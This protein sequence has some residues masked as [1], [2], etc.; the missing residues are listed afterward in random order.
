MIIIVMGVSGSG[1]S[2]I[3][4]ALAEKL[5]F[6]FFDADDF[7]PQSNKDKMASGIP[8]TDE[9][10]YPWLELIVDALSKEN[11]GVLACSALKDTYREIL[12]KAS[13][14][15]RWVYLN[16]DYETIKQRMEQ[17][18]GHFMKADMLK[19]QFDA[20]QAP[21]EAINVDITLSIGEIVATV[22]KNINKAND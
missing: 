22:I 9:D 1:K 8:L 12:N 20:L 19:S 17:R 16:G 7:H 10:R 2:T 18:S 11:N 21:S 5:K 13:D 4:K 3:G 14:D 15:V 6:P